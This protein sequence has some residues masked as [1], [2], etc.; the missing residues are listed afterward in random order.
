MA[1]AERL[2]PQ[3]SDRGEPAWTWA[4]AERLIP[5]ALDK[6]EKN[7]AATTVTLASA[8]GLGPGRKANPARQRSGV[9]LDMGS[10]RKA[11][12]AGFRK[13]HRQKGLWPEANPTAALGTRTGLWLKG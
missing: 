3:D 8:L 4:L 10:G 13:T 9:G 5:L 1:L 2:I 11:N 12:P 6:H 7:R